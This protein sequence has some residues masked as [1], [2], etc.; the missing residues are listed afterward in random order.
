MSEAAIPQTWEYLTMRVDALTDLNKLG[1]EGW[2]LAGVSGTAAPVLYFKRPA[3][4]FRTRVT[5]YQKRRA[6]A[7]AGR[8]LPETEE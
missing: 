5:L 2:E 4:D 7:A 6:Y 8:T 1:R 3:A